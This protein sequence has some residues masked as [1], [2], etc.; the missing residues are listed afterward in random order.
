MKI[1]SPCRCSLK[2]N[3]IRKESRYIHLSI[4]QER[5]IM[6]KIKL[7]SWSFQPKLILSRKVDESYSAS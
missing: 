5:K 1:N 2:M 3:K 4:V 6:I 7:E